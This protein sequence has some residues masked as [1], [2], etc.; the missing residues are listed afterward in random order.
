MDPVTY[1][2][3]EFV[4]SRAMPLAASSPLPPRWV[5]YTSEPADRVVS[6]LA[7]N[8]SNRPPLAVS[9]AVPAVGKGVLD[10]ELLKELVLPDTNTV[11]AS[12][13]RARPPAHSSWLPPR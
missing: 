5:E 13:P 4:G 11:P 7:T 12:A 10:G 2:W 9:W 6:S 3:L 1:T 8:A